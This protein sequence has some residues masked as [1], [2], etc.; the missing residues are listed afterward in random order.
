[1]ERDQRGIALVACEVHETKVIVA[2]AIYKFSDNILC[3]CILNDIFLIIRNLDYFLAYSFSL[4]SESR[5][6]C[7]NT[8]GV[9]FAVKFVECNIHDF[10]DTC[11][12]VSLKFDIDNFVHILG[13]I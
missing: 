5:L 12:I 3:I 10:A 11:I 13:G 8:I 4:V 2:V 7:P 1:M 6:F 9:V